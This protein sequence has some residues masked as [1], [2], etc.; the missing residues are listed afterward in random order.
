MRK[1][2]VT[3]LAWFA[4]FE[5]LLDTC[6]LLIAFCTWTHYN[7]SLYHLRSKAALKEKTLLPSPI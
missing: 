1:A 4:A 5:Q 3:S 2:A 7:I 6:F